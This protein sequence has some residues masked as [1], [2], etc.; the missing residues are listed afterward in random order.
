M[1]TNPAYAG[2]F[3]FGRTK[4][5]RRLDEDGRVVA[6]VRDLP[7]EEWEVCLPGHHPG[8]IDWDT[9]LA[10]RARLRANWRPPAGEG[11]GAAR[12]GRALLQGLVRCG[13]C[14][15]RMQVG[16]TKAR[17]PRYLCARAMQLYGGSRT[18]Q[19]LGGR[20][21]ESAV[22]AEVFAVLEPAAIA[23]TARAL[24]EAEGAHRQRLGAFEL[25]VERAQFEAD[26]AR[27]QFDG[28]EPENRLVARNLERTWEQ[29]LVALRQAQADLDAQR[30][31]RP[32]KLT[33]DEMDWVA[34][35]GADLRAVFDAP[36]TTVR[37]RKL[38]LRA[39]ITDVVVTVDRPAAEVRGRICW[40]GG[41]T[42]DISVDL[43]RVADNAL[44]TD[45]ETVEAVRR[46]AVHYDDATIARHLARRGHVTATG[47]P[48]NKK[49]VTS[50]RRSRGIPGPAPQG[51]AVTPL[52]EDV[53]IV[54]LTQAQ[55]VLG[56]SRSTLHRW[57][58]DG[59]VAAE[60][61]TPG[62]PRRVRIDAALRA[63]VLPELPEGWMGL[64][65]AAKALGVVR[66]TVLDR[67][68]RGELDAVG[69]TRG[70]RAGLAVQVPVP[71][72]RLFSPRP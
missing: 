72:D 38:L 52:E 27:R 11:G 14:G 42:T 16:Y 22:V 46:L 23:A 55:A 33:D 1:L 13:R 6:R 31:R 24:A 69:I 15:R 37:E 48:F 10:N 2:A 21:L 17:T 25:A 59:F 18:C 9:Y 71:Q 30:S 65:E 61:D 66:Q 8:F 4:V 26:R 62:G 56:I 51:A 20:A 60:Q 44:T 5:S 47:R 36:T 12:E 3:V 49:R 45:E 50:L 19:S 34:R 28:C 32:P 53:E 64:A 68:Q 67:I 41:A 58:A 57:I 7:V 70:R 29:R 54:S 63:K 35:A 40:E 43:P 39:L